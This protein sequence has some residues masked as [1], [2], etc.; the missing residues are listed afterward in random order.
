MLGVLD[1]FLETLL[2]E[3]DREAVT[4]VLTSDH[5]NIEDISS[6]GHTANPVPFAAVGPGAED[7][8]AKVK[9]IADVTPALL[10]LL[11]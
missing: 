7:L 1:R 5:G 11:C 10:G 2:R 9:S 8:L 6:P 3:T 4:L